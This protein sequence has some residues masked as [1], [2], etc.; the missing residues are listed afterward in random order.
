MHFLFCW[1][2]LNHPFFCVFFAVNISLS[3]SQ[4]ALFSMHRYLY[5]Q[6]TSSIFY[7]EFRAL[8]SI[9]LF[10]RSL[11]QL[12]INTFAI[13]VT[14]TVTRLKGG[15]MGWASLNSCTKDARAN[16]HST[17]ELSWLIWLW[18]MRYRYFVNDGKFWLEMLGLK[19]CTTSQIV[20]CCKEHE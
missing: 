4:S 6:Q 14:N 3:F 20:R 10:A 8:T 7:F 9:A 18:I 15:M 16:F 19:W 13:L 11:P 12:K 2:A 1:R 5:I 17:S